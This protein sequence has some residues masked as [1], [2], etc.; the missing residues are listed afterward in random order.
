MT[1]SEN[2]QRRVKNETLWVSSS[3]K[4]LNTGFLSP[5][6]S[7]R[8]HWNS[9]V[10]KLK[11]ELWVCTPK[12]FSLIAAKGKWGSTSFNCYYFWT[13]LMRTK[14]RPSQPLLLGCCANSCRFEDAQSM[15][16]WQLVVTRTSGRSPVSN[17]FFPS[18]WILRYFTM[19]SPWSGSIGIV[20]SSLTGANWSKY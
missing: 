17:P 16:F 15:T 20:E 3:S 4:T 6:G 18:L 5:F 9:L 1:F 14:P 2:S 19:I 11:K 7:F 8:E 13:P 10:W 12:T